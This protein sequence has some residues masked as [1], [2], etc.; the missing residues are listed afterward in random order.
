MHA[1]RCMCLMPTPHP[2]PSP[3]AAPQVWPQVGLLWAG[4]AKI[5]HLLERPHKALEAAEQAI[6]ILGATHGG[7]G[8]AVA[9]AA[10]VKFEAQQELLHRRQA[11]PGGGSDD[12]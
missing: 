6:R 8:S 2:R 1:W 5:E 7:S 3:A 10:R 11:L 4:V 9:A 12:D